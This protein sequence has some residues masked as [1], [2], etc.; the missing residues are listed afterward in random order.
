LRDL[1]FSSC[2]SLSSLSLHC[3]FVVRAPFHCAP[4]S[5]HVSGPCHLVHLVPQLL[6]SVSIFL[7]FFGPL[8]SHRR[9]SLFLVCVL[10]VIPC[11]L[12]VPLS[13]SFRIRFIAVPRAPLIVVVVLSTRCSLSLL[14]H[15]I[16]TLSLSLSEI[17]VFVPIARAAICSGS[18]DPLTQCVAVLFSP[19]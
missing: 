15:V 2:Q 5:Y 19:V 8:P 10:V 1:P 16:Q 7:V 13:S 3:R 9:H 11:S 4:S 14:F 17:V 12:F 6:T 18:T